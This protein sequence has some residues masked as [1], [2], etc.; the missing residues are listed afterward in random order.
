MFQSKNEYIYA[1]ALSIFGGVS[2]LPFENLNIIFGVIGALFTASMFIFKKINKIVD[3]YNRLTDTVEK[4]HLE[5]FTE[6]GSLKDI[7]LIFNDTL[8]RIE[9]SQ[10]IL[11]QRSRSSLHYHDYPLFETDKNGSLIW[12]N[13]RFCDLT[14]FQHEEIL[15]NNWY[16][17]IDEEER[18][19]FIEEFNSCLRMCRQLDTQTTLYNGQIVKFYGQPYK[20]T[21]LH[22]EGF[23]FKVLS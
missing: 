7:V 17:V 1:L 23:L 8:S 11:E 6:Q 2:F 15:G 21:D 12:S 9:T 16:S 14:G 20:I 5:M 3:S 13:D 4:I 22:Q 10:K 19:S 18:E